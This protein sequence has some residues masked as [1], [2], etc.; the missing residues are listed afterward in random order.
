MPDPQ[1][2]PL[3]AE[4]GPPVDPALSSASGASSPQKAKDAQ[5][6]HEKQRNAKQRVPEVDEV[7]DNGAERERDLLKALGGY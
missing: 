4:M 5:E 1:N 3:D 7:S 6:T 2:D